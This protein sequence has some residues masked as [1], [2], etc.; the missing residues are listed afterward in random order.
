MCNVTVVTSDSCKRRVREA[1]V[2]N[3]E[4][5]ATGTYLAVFVIS[6]REESDAAHSSFLAKYIHQK[7]VN[8]F[9]IIEN[10]VRKVEEVKS[11]GECNQ[12]FENADK[13]LIHSF[14]N[15]FLLKLPLH[16]LVEREMYQDKEFSILS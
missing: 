1:F 12:N 14:L 16:A 8:Y 5:I 2:S 11:C 13:S 7:T 9:N 4:H 3:D 15:K 6:M 10:V